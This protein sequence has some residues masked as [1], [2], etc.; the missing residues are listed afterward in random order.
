M[1]KF[2]LR[3]SGLSQILLRWKEAAL[4]KLIF[5]NVTAKGPQGVALIK[6]RFYYFLHQILV[7]AGYLKSAIIHDIRRALGQKIKDKAGT[8]IYLKKLCAYKDH[9]ITWFYT[10]V[11]DLHA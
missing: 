8:L 6:D 11:T 9:R 4:N 7:I 2:D 5:R 1:A 3:E 10:C